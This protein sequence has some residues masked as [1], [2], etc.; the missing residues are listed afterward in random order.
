MALNRAQL[1]I[2]PAGASIGAVKAGANV[3]IV[4]GV[5]SV[6]GGGGVTQ[7]VAGTGITITPSGGT[8]AVNIA[9]TTPPAGANF[10]A[11]TVM[12]FSQAAAPT[13][14]T[15]NTDFDKIN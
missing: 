7:I 6:S 10:P 11:G 15:K 12:P 5:I 14:W 2:P 8:G 9:L 1:L 13:N 3:T 4:G